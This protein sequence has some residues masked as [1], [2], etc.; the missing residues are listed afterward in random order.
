MKDEAH[1]MMYVLDTNGDGVIGRIERVYTYSPREV[2]ICWGAKE[3]QGGFFF[4]V[5]RGL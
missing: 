1:H 2:V 5:A 4:F 3:G